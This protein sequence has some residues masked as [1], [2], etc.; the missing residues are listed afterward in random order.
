MTNYTKILTNELA[1]RLYDLDIYGAQ[2]CDETPET[3]ADTIKVD[4][5]SIIEH[6]VDIVE[7]LQA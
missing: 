1:Q 7:D 2:D 5:L 3:I 6:L 4:P